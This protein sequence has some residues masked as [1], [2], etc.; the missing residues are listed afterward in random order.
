MSL[1]ISPVQNDKELREFI[2][3]PWLVY[4][5]DPNWVP[6]LFFERL[7]FFDKQKNPFFEHAEADYFIARRDGRAI[8]TIAA[9]LNHRHNEF[10]EEN[11]AHFGVFEVQNDPEA[12]NGLLQAACEWAAGR[13]VDKIVGPMNLSTNDECGMLLEGY[14]RPPVLLMTYNPA[15]Y[16]DFMATAGFEKAMDLWAWLSSEQGL[17]A[18]LTDKMKRV[19]AKVQARYGLVIR[20][21]NL[22]DWDNEV[23]RIKAIYN[24]AWQKNWGFVPMTD[25]EIN[26]LANSFKPILD[27]DLVFMV[28][29]D[30]QA[31]G[32]SLSV[33]DVNQILGRLR[34]GPSRLS[35]YLGA[36]RMIWSR[37]PVHFFRVV[38][39]GVLE[40]YRVH[41]VD[42]L[43]YYES[44]QAGLKKGYQAAEASWI[45]EVNDKMNRVL[46]MMGGKVY[47]T[48]RIYEKKLVR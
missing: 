30:G 3:V 41:G 46:Q 35:S 22:K 44:L 33:P 18:H 10:Q 20:P 17:Q 29:K 47:K 23:E 37:Q 12:A 45:L 38:A 16:H 6:P 48:Y 5:N 36:A 27:P 42:A 25:A 39:M 28:E 31:V 9:I 2:K 24:Q 15:Y 8:G 7:E 14:D 40:E 21:V 43:M 26:R 34:P 32:F 4:Q 19:V 11:V 13:G 1:H